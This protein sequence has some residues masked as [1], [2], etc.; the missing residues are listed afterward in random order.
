MAVMHARSN[1]PSRADRQG[2]AKTEALIAAARALAPVLTERAP[3]AERDRQVSDATIAA[4]ADAGIFQMLTPQ[5]FGGPELGLRDFVSVMKELSPLCASTGW[6]TSFYIAHNWM[7]CLLPLEAQQ[8]IFAGGPS[9]L[10]PVMV[11]PTVTA[12]PVEGGYRINGRAKWATGSSHASWCMVSGIVKG[13]S[14]APAILMF[15]MPWSEARVVDTWFTAGMAATASND[16]EFDNVFVPERR[17]L[18][19]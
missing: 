8:E 16:V 19:V 13:G 5:R 11:A 2:A 12:T 7:W 10:G 3:Q 6:L 1:T 18:D 4:I 15:A 17:T 9:A 14:G